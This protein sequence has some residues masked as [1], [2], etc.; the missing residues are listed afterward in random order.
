MRYHSRESRFETM[1][2]AY[3]ADLYR[4]AYWLCRDRPLAEDL[5]QE[6]F[7][8]AWKSWDALQD[9]NAVKAWLFTILRREHAR[10][11]ERKQLD[12]EEQELDEVVA[13]GTDGIAQLEM[14]EALFKLPAAYREPLIL[15]ALAGFSGR[16]ISAILEVSEAAVMTRLTRARQA[17][18]KLIEP[19]EKL[20]KGRTL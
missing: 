6:T 15:Q 20:V 8:R 12:I 2:R 1:V 9:E 16:E 3:S 17:L 11:Y 10:R 14:R 19:A 18:R 5:V 7:T 4:F 13:T